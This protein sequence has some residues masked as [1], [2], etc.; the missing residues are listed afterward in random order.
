MLAWKVRQAARGQ[1]AARPPIGVIERI[2]IDAFVGAGLPAISVDGIASKPAPTGA[3]RVRRYEQRPA[4]DWRGM[5][6]EGAG[7]GGEL[8]QVRIR[9]L[10]GCWWL[11]KHYLPPLQIN[12]CG[13]KKTF[14]CHVNWS[15]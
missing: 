12:L 1:G 15:N 5:L 11:A 10:T 14:F 2:S 13:D 4:P 9:T 3:Q 8:Q 6:Q 7:K